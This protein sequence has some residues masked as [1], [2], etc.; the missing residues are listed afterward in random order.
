MKIN[1]PNRITA[2]ACTALLAVAT[3]SMAQPLVDGSFEA[4]A[5]GVSPVAWTLNLSGGTATNTTAYA[6]SGSQSLVIDSTGVG[7]WSSPNALQEFPAA[8]GDEFL[9][10]GHMLRSAAIPGGS[11]G[12]LKIEFRDGANAVLLPASASLG[13]INNA[14]PG[15]E[16]LPF[17]NNGNVAVDTWLFTQARGVAPAGTAKVQFYVLNVNAPDSS[18]PMYFDNITATKITV[19]PPT[20]S[21]TLPVNNAL[22]GS[23]FT[24]N[25][26]ASVIPGAITNAYFYRSNNVPASPNVLLG[27][28]NTSPYRYSI[29]GLANG[30]YAL[31]VVAYGT[32][33]VGS[34]ISVTSSVV[35]ITVN[36]AAFNLVPNGDFEIPGGASWGTAGPAATTFLA[37]GGNPGG[38]G[39]MDSTGGWGVLVMEN[40]ATEGLS[41]PLLGIT[42]GN[43]YAF[44][45]D[46][47]GIAG[48]ESAGIKIEAWNAGVLVGNSGDIKFTAGT[49]WATF[50]PSW[51]VPASASSIKFVPLSVDGGHVGFDN[52]GVVSTVVSPLSASITSPANGATVSPNFT[53]NAFASAPGGVTSVDFY[54][55]N[56]LLATDS[57][58]G[59]T[60]SW[61]ITGAADGPLS[62]KIV[63]N[64]SGGSLT[65]SVVTVTVVSTATVYVDP[66][67]PWQGFMNVSE[68]PQN[69]SAFAFASSW[70]VG[71]LRAS[72]SGSTLTLSPNTINDP[73][74]FWY[75][76]SGGP[77]SVGNK[78]MEANM[79]V[80][81]VGTL[82]GLTV[83]FKGMCA[84]NTMTTN[85][86][87]GGTYNSL[88]N[89]WTCVAVIKDF[90]P[91]Y[92]SFNIS[93][94][95]VTNGVPFSVSLL[96]NPDPAR[97][98]QYGFVTTGPNVWSTDVAPFGNV[99]ITPAPT[100]SISPSVSGANVNLS[101]PSFNGYTYQAQY[102]NNL[103]DANWTNLGSTTNGTG[104]TIILTDTHTLPNRFYRVSA[105]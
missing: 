37:A 4:D 40:N 59:P 2:L 96:T 21:I 93:S 62:L 18:G 29:S 88:G 52:V 38:Y 5:P 68:T 33:D 25:A 23:N 100:F 12:L 97:K 57:S 75:T 55:N 19:S 39:D 24:I 87:F 66:S 58:A 69:G 63:A 85:G 101:F 20:A 34:P 91:D 47:I 71:D 41:L 31:R 44:S 35:N 98:V 43:T 78:T 45:F 1:R 79:Y 13:Q 22:V 7:A 8:A 11:F 17:L 61:P 53:I 60:Y 67:K 27:N 104:A 3:A 73:A 51:T 90:A 9:L 64:H 48:G 70:G 95:P 105:Q 50:T 94:V 49:T 42:A 32:N 74:A 15:I 26:N 102:K 84:S 103:T 72:W 82:S 65:S 30:S 80:E 6:Q 54:A 99:V 83:T 36:A 81:T 56:V 89:G 10:T 16:S 76:P 28:D 92:S 77:G 14:F 46:M 86:V